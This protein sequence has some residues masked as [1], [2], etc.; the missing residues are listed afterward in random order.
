MERVESKTI[1]DRYPNINQHETDNIENNEIK[2]F[3]WAEEEMWG[4]Y[5]LSILRENDE[6]YIGK[7]KLYYFENDEWEKNFFDGMK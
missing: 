2:F 1:G 6:L 3:I 4:F 7:E 5:V